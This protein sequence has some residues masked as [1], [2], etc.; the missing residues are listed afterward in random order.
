MRIKRV[1]ALRLRSA[2]LALGVLDELA[3]GIAVEAFAINAHRGSGE[4]AAHGTIDQRFEQYRRPSLV[5]GGVA[6][7]R[8]HRL[9][10][11]DLGGEMDDAVDVLERAGNHVLVADITD[12]QLGFVGKV[13]G[14]APIAVDLFDQAIEHANLVPTAKK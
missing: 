3:L 13:F 5:D 7:D 8:V 12:D 6:F 14:P 11:A 1:P 10:D 2:S 4:D 9:A